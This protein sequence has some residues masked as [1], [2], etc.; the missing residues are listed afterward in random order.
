M[1]AAAGTDHAPAVDEHHAA[2]DPDRGGRVSRTRQH[3][4]ERRRG[5]ELAP[6]LVVPT[7]GRRDA[8]ALETTGSA[9]STGSSQHAVSTRS[10]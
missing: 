4:P 6:G 7:F 8:T 1:C 2:A 5:L 9:G 10:A 3:R